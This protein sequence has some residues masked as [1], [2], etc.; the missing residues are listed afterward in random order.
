MCSVEQE[1][2][3]KVL[4]ASWNVFKQQVIQSIYAVSALPIDVTESKDKS[5]SDSECGT[6]IDLS[7][8]WSRGVSPDIYLIDHNS[9]TP[10]DFQEQQMMA[11]RSS[12]SQGSAARIATREQAPYLRSRI[13]DVGKEQLRAIRR[14]LRLRLGAITPTKCVS[15][16]SL[17]EAVS[18]LGLTRY[19]LKEVNDLV[20]HLACFV[21]LR[22]DKWKKA[23]PC[24]QKDDDCPGH[25]IWEWPKLRDSHVH[26]NTSAAW[27]EIDHPK[28]PPASVVPVQALMEILLAEDGD[29]HRRIFGPSLPA[30]R[31]IREVLLAGDTNRL[32]AELTFVRLNDLAA[33]PDPTPPLLFVEAMITW[34]IIV[35][36]ILMGIQM[37]PEYSG[38]NGWFWCE[39]TFTSLLSVE[40]GLR[41]MMMGC[42][43]FFCG[44]QV[45]WNL[46]DLFLLACALTDVIKEVITQNPN[47]LSG[48][49]L[50]R[51]CR[52]VRLVRIIKAFRLKFMGELRLM[53]KGLIAGLRTLSL[54]FTL[55]F[56]VLYMISGFATTTIGASKETEELG[57]QAYFQTLPDSMFTAFRCFTG[58]C[59]NDSGQPLHSLLASRFGLPFIACYVASYMLVTMGIFNVILAVY[60]DITMKAAKENEALTAE[61]HSR[62]SIRI[63]RVTRELL[64]KFAAA[65]RM[66]QDLDESQHPGIQRLDTSMFTD[67]QIQENIAITKE[68]FL[69]VIQDRS[70][71]A[72]MDDLE[73]PR[74]RA[75]L[76][77]IIDSDGSGTLQVVELVQGL[78][79]IRGEVSKSDTVASYLATK[80]LQET[81]TTL[82]EDFS[83]QFAELRTELQQRNRYLEMHGTVSNL[84]NA[85]SKVITTPSGHLPKKMDSE[86]NEQPSRIE[87]YH[88]QTSSPNLQPNGTESY[89]LHSSLSADLDK[90]LCDPRETGPQNIQQLK[91]TV[92]PEVSEE[93]D[94]AP[95]QPQPYQS[96]NI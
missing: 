75:N 29:V 38:W 26:N 10:S 90:P 72:L 95:P 62:E 93:A 85:I 67:D 23:S 77:E 83:R 47:A 1:V 5:A 12:E 31:A 9:I 32:V 79:K 70:V 18:A 73:L 94:T 27:V 87:S 20:D 59:V 24:L 4:D 64:K 88:L 14:R 2:L 35:N 46:F 53:V 37:D 30:F 49:S 63:A 91:P 21:N 33:P 8:I 78:L 45:C 34:V 7:Q 41:S 19:S 50:L 80:S 60:V 17:H 36:A 13:S 11:R 42:R 92:K 51:L 52:L 25:A 56:V 65:F 55:L 48:S 61:Q 68:L 54:S 6:G 15:G 69:L 81:V 76:F 74:D 39:L 40:V 84:S 16:K 43:Q 89:R 22:F 57:L 71:Q 44:P 28:R 66:F 58:E 82:K 96:S 3:E 86:P